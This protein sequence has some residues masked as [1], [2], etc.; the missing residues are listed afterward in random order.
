MIFQQELEA[1]CQEAPGCHEAVLMN[2]DGLVVFRHVV[3]ESD[4]NAEDF[5]VELTDAIKRTQQA[6]GSANGGGLGEFTLAFD[7]A[8][9]VVRFLKDDHFVALLMEPTALE[10]RGRY[11]LRCHSLALAQELV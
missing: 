5:L 3:K 10:G 11:A 8:T 6:V 4:I 1:I 2:F 7:K 9:L